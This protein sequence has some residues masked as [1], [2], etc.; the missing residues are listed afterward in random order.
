MIHSVRRRLSGALGALIIFMLLLIAKTASA[1]SPCDCIC[2]RG[3]SE[4]GWRVVMSNKPGCKIYEAI[5][6]SV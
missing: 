1:N 2:D 5:K 3:E 6:K 4:K